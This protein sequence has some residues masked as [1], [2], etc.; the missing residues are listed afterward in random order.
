MVYD[1]AKVN[2]PPNRKPINDKERI[3]ILEYYL[4]IILKTLKIEDTDN[5][6]KWG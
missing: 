2:S 6:I 1:M 5:N 3:D 4:S